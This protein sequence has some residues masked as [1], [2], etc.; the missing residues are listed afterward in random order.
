MCISLSL[1][2]YISLSIYIYIYIYI[3]KQIAAEAPEIIRGEGY[4]GFAT[5]SAQPHVSESTRVRGTGSG[6]LRKSTGTNGRK[7]FSKPTG[8][9]FCS[10]RNLRKSP[11]TSGSL[12]ENVI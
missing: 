6:F 8:S 12:R 10:Y 3:C 11:E 4:I 9:L 2:L 7:R 1:S 5:E